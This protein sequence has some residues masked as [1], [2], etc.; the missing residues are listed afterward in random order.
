[1]PKKNRGKTKI[2]QSGEEETDRLADKITGLTVA[3]ETDV[4]DV[5]S[6]KNK[7]KNKKGK[8]DSSISKKMAALLAD[9]E[10][11]DDSDNEEDIGIPEPEPVLKTRWKTR[12]YS[13]SRSRILSW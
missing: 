3:G 7:K 6:D 10:D 12:F 1:M 13:R 11:E 5:Q 4:H 2:E 9:M 8:S